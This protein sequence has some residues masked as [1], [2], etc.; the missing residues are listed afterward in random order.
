MRSTLEII[1]AAKES[2]PVTEEELKMALLAE[3]GF[4]YFTEKRLS[5]FVEAIESGKKML[6]DFA[7]SE[8][9]HWEQTKFD[10]QKK[11]PTE[12]LGPTNIPGNPEYEARYAM[13]KRIIKAATGLDV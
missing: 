13:G 3:S 12:W 7:M 1:I 4:L 11:D 10:A 8:A 2:S 9:K 5:Q 6:I